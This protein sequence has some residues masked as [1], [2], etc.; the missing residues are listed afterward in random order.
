MEC[1]ICLERG[2]FCQHT[3][4]YIYICT[5][6]ILHY[7]SLSLSL[8]I[9]IFIHMFIHICLNILSNN[10]YFRSNC[11][12]CY[13]P[14]IL[15]RMFRYIFIENEKRMPSVSKILPSKSRYPYSNTLPSILRPQMS[16]TR[17]AC[18]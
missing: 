13:W 2:K 7:L 8:S 3:Y 15:Q 1:A 17:N 6:I 14:Y 16:H 12:L 5:Y 9:Y 10:Y 11:T 4:I 18:R